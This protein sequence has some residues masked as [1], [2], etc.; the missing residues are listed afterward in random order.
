[1]GVRGVRLALLVGAWALLRAYPYGRLPPRTRCVR[2]SDVRA[3]DA[4]STEHSEW[5]PLLRLAE[6]LSGP[7]TTQTLLNLIALGDRW[8][9]EGHAPVFATP[10]DRAHSPGFDRVPGCTAD[11]R[12]RV[13]VDELGLVRVRGFADS[14][15][16]LGML[17]L[18]GRGINGSHA[19]RL[20]DM[21]VDAVAAQ[22]AVSAL[23]PP[24]RLNG[25]VN[26]LRLA[27]SQATRL[28]EGALTEQTS[29]A[30]SYTEQVALLLSGGVDSSVALKLLLDQGLSVRAF[31][32]KI[33]LEDESAHLGDCPWAEDLAFCEATC[34]Q[35]GVPLETVSLQ[36]EYWAEV[37][38]YA[39]AE[40][41]RGR[42]PNPDVMC[43]SRV[44]FGVFVAHFGRHFPLVA[45]GHYAQLERR[46][47]ATV[48]RQSP[49][50]VKDQSYFLSA[51]TQ[52]QLS[53]CVFPIG[54]MLKSEVR[55]LAEEFA[56]PTAARRD[57][58]GICFLGKL[59]FDDFIE[60]YLGTRP[61]PIL[62]RATGR[63]VG[64]HR[65][66]WFHTIGQ[67]RGVG[68]LLSEGVHAGPWFVAAKDLEANALLVTNQPDAADPSCSR[69]LVEDVS[70]IGAAPA[71][72]D[73][74]AGAQLLVKLRHGPGMAPCTVRRAGRGLHVLLASPD[75]GIAAGQFAAFYR[76]GDC[77][78]AGVVADRD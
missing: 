15:V 71:G 37:V 23:L 44:K 72:L 11:S 42:T 13:T 68:L 63:R 31:Y 56:L 73:E 28:I 51:L 18:V 30:P 40:A 74:E 10:S 52:Q 14:R 24:G 62:D 59:P 12:L 66:L 69:L 7:T 3:A 54:H 46:D 20:A 47:G 70:W 76:D 22:C 5:Q 36:K 38:Q 75:R 58:Q 77:L 48:L 41:R 57:S 64:T 35:L 34:A 39:L 25:F 8:T 27:R 29:A 2:A 1:M 53:R 50:P 67:R 17:A 26:M 45:T 16:A 33:W 43:N 65:G 32:L 4:M 49:D 19:R 21:D 78:G 61:G 9:A 60:H 6:E 55:R